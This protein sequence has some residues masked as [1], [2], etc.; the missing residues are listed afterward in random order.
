MPADAS[1]PSIHPSIIM[2]SFPLAHAPSY[3]F[4]TLPQVSVHARVDLPP[5]GVFAILTQPDNSGVFRAIEAMPYR[6]VLRSSGGVGPG[7]VVRRSIEVEHVARWRAGPLLTGTLSTRLVV[8]EDPATGEVAFRLAPGGP[9]GFMAAF[10]GAWRVVPFNQAALDALLH[11]QQQQQQG[12]GGGGGGGG[13]KD[14]EVVVST[15]AASGAWALAEAALARA[16]A[17]PH[18]AAR[19]SHGGGALPTTGASLVTLT[20]SVGP[21]VP[22]P[23][24]LD[25]LVSAIC[26]RQVRGLLQ[27]LRSEAARRR[28]REAGQWR[29]GGGGGGGG[30]GRRGDGNGSGSAGV[31]VVEGVGSGGGG[32]GGAG[33]NRV[34]GRLLW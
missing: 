16:R 20:Q 26:A 27:D 31:V 28:H 34:R 30:G 15:G 17:L 11:A 14:E 18:A 29:D 6:R 25:R 23:P 21:R 4:F 3:F 22:L 1:L 10:E 12:G 32:G 9:R 5:A 33:R 19:S 7:G 13:G 8:D 24:P 2:S